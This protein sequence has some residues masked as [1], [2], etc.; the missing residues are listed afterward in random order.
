MCEVGDPE[1]AGQLADVQAL[2]REQ[3]EQPQP[4]GVAEQTVERGGVHRIY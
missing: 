2:V 4:D 3:A 1:D